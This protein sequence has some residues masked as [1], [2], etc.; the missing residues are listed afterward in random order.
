MNYKIE[1]AR[2][3]QRRRS[4]VIRLRYQRQVPQIHACGPANAIAE[5]TELAIE[6]ECLFDIGRSQV[7]DPVY[8]EV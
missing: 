1:L 4:K 6:P 3:S 7:V 2:R 5:S 8:G